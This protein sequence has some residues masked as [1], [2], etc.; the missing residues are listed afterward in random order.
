MRFCNISKKDVKTCGY[1]EFVTE[2]PFTVKNTYRGVLDVLI[3][4]GNYSGID[5]EVVVN[6][7]KYSAIGKSKKSITI[8]LP[9]DVDTK[10][11]YGTASAS[12]LEK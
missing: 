4:T 3:R 10:T 9:K 2:V 7:A 12:A 1:D 5:L 11:A 6:N 8:K